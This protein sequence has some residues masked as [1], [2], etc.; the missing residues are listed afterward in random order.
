MNRRAVTSYA[1][2]PVVGLGAK[3]IQ[4]S[5]WMIG[6]RWSIRFMGLIS[7]V[8]VARVLMPE[9]FGIFAVVVAVLALLDTLTNI[10]P[11]LAIIRHPDPQRRHYDTAWTL[12]VLV[13]LAAALMLALAAPL[14]VLI[15][16]DSRYGPVAL[17]MAGGLAVCGFR[18]VGIADFRRNLEF[19]RDFK[20]EVSVKLVGAISTIIAAFLL[21]SYWALVVGVFVRSMAHLILSYAMHPYRPRWSLAARAELLGFSFWTAM[22][23]FAIFTTGKADLFVIGKFYSP[24]I[25]GWYAVSADLARMATSELL[26]PI[27]RAIFPGLARMQHDVEWKK[28]NLKKVFNITATIAAATGVML[29]VMAEPAIA[30]VYG[31]RFRPA[32]GLL[33]LFALASA[34]EGFG[35]PIG[36]YL[37]VI[38][39]LKQLAMLFLVQGA[40]LLGVL[41]YLA[42][43]GADVETLAL[44]RILVALLMLLRLFYLLTVL[45]ELSWRDVLIAWFRPIVAA[46]A[47]YFVLHATLSVWPWGDA[48]ALLALVPAG[49]AVYAL[50]L[51][52][53]WWSLGRPPGI[54]EELVLRLQQRLKPMPQA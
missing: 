23:S 43:S 44:A 27:A 54:E 35:Q 51:F 21:R 40:V 42:S 52:S 28:R 15:Y 32:A 50:F 7:T 24:T 38:N 39:R 6:M 48:L 16:D 34:I 19:S 36:Q 1:Q 53:V 47:M 30:T 4:G 10:G 33:A 49:A 12:T 17:A 2:E 25:T 11:D 18:N 31:E 9:D 45:K 37:V 5:A 22:R 3:L 26:H 20:F 29:F 13:H 46:T 14:V 8:I 41:Y